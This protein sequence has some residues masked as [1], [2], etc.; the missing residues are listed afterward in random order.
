MNSP[1]YALYALSKKALR[2]DLTTSLLPPS[3]SSAG[4]LAPLVVFTNL[5][6]LNVEFGFLPA[7]AIG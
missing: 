7:L 3:A 2:F 1:S 4:L 5:V 6:F